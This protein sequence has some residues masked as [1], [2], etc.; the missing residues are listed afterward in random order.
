MS[1]R[2]NDTRRMGV[3]EMGFGT[4]C[5]VMRWC[6]IVAVAVC[7]GPSVFAQTSVLTVTYLEGTAE[8]RAGGV[9]RPLATG[10]R[11]AG[12][13]RVRVG[14]RAM[15]ELG[16][17]RQRVTL[18]RAGSY[19]LAVVTER[20]GMSRRGGLAALIFERLRRVVRAPEGDEESS[21]AGV[22][23]AE[24][25]SASGPAWVGAESP[26]T[27]IADGIAALQD[28]DA[29]EAWY[30]FDEAYAVAG[31]GVEDEAR[32][33]L[34]YA[35]YA[36][37]DLRD[38]L[39][40]LEGLSP[41]PDTSFYDS[42]VLLLGQVLIETHAYAE[43]AD[44]LRSYLDGDRDPAQAQDARLLLGVALLAQGDDSAARNYL[45]AARD[46]DPES[47]AGVA[48]GELLAGM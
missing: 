38:A 39:E 41:D 10:D 6:A 9:W 46:A 15:V 29:E 1:L 47:T 35:S 18:W 16:Q 43:A 5:R 36:R 4:R 19:D 11:V 34:A 13:A 3:A 33:Y 37:E 30:L 8:V 45:R 26:E 21:T 31:P 24:A 23:A 20:A 44:E 40:V 14:D 17:G 25:P 42:H 48:A 32:F 27:L 22:R 7:I 2:G 12:D 28:R